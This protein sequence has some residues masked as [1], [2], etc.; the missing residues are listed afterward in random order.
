MN[1]ASAIRSARLG[2]GLTQARLAAAAGTSQAT[3]SAYESGHKQPS[4]ATLERLL[5]ACGGRLEVRAPAGTRSRAE[6]ERAGRHLR[7]V[8]ALAEAL[9]YRTTPDLRYPPLT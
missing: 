8:L 4:V 9:P 6:L 5:A 3:L 2:A 7:D 1:L